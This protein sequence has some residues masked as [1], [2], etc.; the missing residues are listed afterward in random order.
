MKM[1]AV[2][3]STLRFNVIPIKIMVADPRNRKKK[4]HNIHPPPQ[5]TPDSKSVLEKQE[6][7]GRST[8]LFQMMSQRHRIKQC[9]SRAPSWLRWLSI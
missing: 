5:M 3:E 7:A 8:F 4:T 1:S 2:P 9:G 6:R